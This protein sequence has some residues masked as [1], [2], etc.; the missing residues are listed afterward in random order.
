MEC[1]RSVHQ[2]GILFHDYELLL[3]GT[4]WC[5]SSVGLLSYMLPV[6]KH[7]CEDH[8][9]SSRM[10]DNGS[11]LGYSYILPVMK[12]LCEEHS[13]ARMFD[14]RSLLGYTYLADHTGVGS[15]VGLVTDYFIVLWCMASTASS[16]YCE[17]CALI[18]PSSIVTP[19]FLA[20]VLILASRRPTFLAS[21]CVL[22][23]SF[24]IHVSISSV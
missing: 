8:S 10:F 3:Y 12:H 13:T 20:T 23:W 1:P 22:S 16:D 15:D 4:A 9:T 2:L 5:S 24:F 17:W 18:I 11:L 19:A 7:L 14:D 6:M 21:V